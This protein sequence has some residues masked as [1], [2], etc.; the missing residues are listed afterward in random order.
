V[1]IVLFV[2]NGLSFL[3]L[4]DFNGLAP[5]GAPAAPK[6]LFLLVF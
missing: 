5:G 1:K 4:N 3:F 2:F 6:P